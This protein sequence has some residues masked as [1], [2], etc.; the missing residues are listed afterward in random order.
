VPQTLRISKRN[1]AYQVLASLRTNRVKRHRSRTFLLE[2][3]RPIGSALARGWTFDA[4]VYES[5]SALSRWAADVV[6]RASAPVHYEVSRELLSELSGKEDASELL[7]VLRMPEDDLARIPVAPGLLV[8]VMDR[9]SNPGNL[10]TLVRSC[11]AF[12]V[13]GVIVTGHGVD[14]YDAAT[15]TASRGSLFAVPVVRAGSHDDVVRWI[16]AV[17][18][19]LGACRIVGADERGTVDISQHDF[20]PPTVVMFGNEAQGLSRAYLEACETLVRI[21]MS[22]SASSLNVSVAASIVFYE[23]GRQRRLAASGSA[24]VR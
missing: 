22:G 6:S 10:G 1:S 5:P 16:A 4:L 8:A 23:A 12:G 2:G 20:T 3:V 14:L 11:D 24:G 13:H 21:P 15:I 17:R 19:A 9:P 7:A 18:I